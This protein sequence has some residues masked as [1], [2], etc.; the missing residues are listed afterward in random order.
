MHLSLHVTQVT[1]ENLD[2]ASQ[3]HKVKKL[4]FCAVMD[5]VKLLFILM[6]IFCAQKPFATCFFLCG[7]ENRAAGQALLRQKERNIKRRAASPVA[8]PGM[9]QRWAGVAN[10]GGR[11]L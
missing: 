5:V 2:K 4:A 6:A 1:A 11:R 7:S 3:L 10:A 8:S 9:P